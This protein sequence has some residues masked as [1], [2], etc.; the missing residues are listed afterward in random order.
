M[1]YELNASLPEG[2]SVRRILGLAAFGKSS[3]MCWKIANLLWRLPRIGTL[4]A[5][6]I[7]LENDTLERFASGADLRSSSGWVNS[8]DR[9]RSARRSGGG[10]SVGS[11]QSCP[12]GERVLLSR[13]VKSIDP[14]RR[15]RG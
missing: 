11:R 7:A 13:G 5:A 2:E 4:L 14:R 3:A 6:L 12:E 9:L 8:T 10:D 15:H 1:R